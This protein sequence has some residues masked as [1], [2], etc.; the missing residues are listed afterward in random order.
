MENKNDGRSSS[1]KP[2]ATGNQGA[3]S[4]RLRRAVADSA[5]PVLFTWLY[6]CGICD[7]MQKV[8][9]AV[10]QLRFR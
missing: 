8:S 5:T 9:S 3:G 2:A 7:R 6:T 1:E 4:L 10:V